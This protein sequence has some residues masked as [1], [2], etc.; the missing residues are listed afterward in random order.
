MTTTP[1][2]E[3]NESNF[4]YVTYSSALTNYIGLNPSLIDEVI[5]QIFQ[6]KIFKGKLGN[7]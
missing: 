3:L 4:G 2:K 5:V 6:K 1:T 7:C